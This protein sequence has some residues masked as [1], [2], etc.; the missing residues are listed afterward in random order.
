MNRNALSE[1]A[2][3]DSVWLKAAGC[4]LQTE[5]W[6]EREHERTGQTAEVLYRVV[7]NGAVV[8]VTGWLTVAEVVIVEGDHEPTCLA[9]LLRR[10]RAVLD[11]LRARMDPEELARQDL[12]RA[13]R[14][15]YRQRQQQNREGA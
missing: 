2:A 15:E 5:I 8:G 10:A 1:Q 9:A 6:G 11:I 13:E 4:E 12:E 7:A 14:L 3:H